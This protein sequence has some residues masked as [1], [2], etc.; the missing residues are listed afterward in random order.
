MP[1]LTREK[2]EAALAA[3]R[4]HFAAYVH[5]DA[6][7]KGVPTLHAPGW[8]IAAEGF[9]PS[10]WSYLAASGGIDDDLLEVLTELLG[11]ER[12]RENATIEPVTLPAGVQVE[13][14][15]GWLLALYSTD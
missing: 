15:Y 10:N 8:T 5:P 4:S 12:A 11:A 6:T 7:D 3:L 9:L 13:P 14:V 1:T 2:S